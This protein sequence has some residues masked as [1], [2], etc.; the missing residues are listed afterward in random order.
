MNEV[1]LLNLRKAIENSGLQNK[2]L[3]WGASDKSDCI[4]EMI[5]K[6]GYDICGFIDSNHDNIKEYKGYKV[7]GRELLDTDVT[8]N[9]ISKFKVCFKQF[10]MP[11][12]HM[13]YVTENEDM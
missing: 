6:W 12:R 2:I 3:I 8:G 4:L 11:E 9:F 7:Y 13:I 5:K 10:V 1:G